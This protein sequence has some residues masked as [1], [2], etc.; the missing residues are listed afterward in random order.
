MSELLESKALIK[1]IS[2]TAIVSFWI[3]YTYDCISYIWDIFYFPNTPK[4][5]ILIVSLGYIAYGFQF[6]LDC[7]DESKSAKYFERWILFW[8]CSLL[9]LTVLV[10][11]PSIVHH[12]FQM[13]TNGRISSFP[14]CARPEGEIL[15]K[16]AIPLFLQAPYL[17][18][19]EKQNTSD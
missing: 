2:T 1:K 19:T 10:I 9:T 11:Y 15:S 16:L 6:I 8:V 14:E 18:I 13:C 5:D 7:S 12:V 17:F 4:I 3:I